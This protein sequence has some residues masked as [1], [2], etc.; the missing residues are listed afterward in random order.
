MSQD[1]SAL[2]NRYIH[3]AIG[4]MEEIDHGFARKATRHASLE[5][6]AYRE[7]SLL[8]D[9]G[10]S[11]F[12]A[13]LE[14]EHPAV[15]LSAATDLLPFDEELA[16]AELSALDKCSGI[17]GFRAFQVLK[18][19]REGYWKGKQLRDQSQRPDVDSE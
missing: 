16:T 12:L 5:E 13:L 18:Q 4:Y 8:P 10:E 14:H 7:L 2:I 11:I 1:S 19:W 3:G 17:L 6:K 15:R 9:R